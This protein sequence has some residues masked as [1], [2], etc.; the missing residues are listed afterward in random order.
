MV[1]VMCVCVMVRVRVC[2]FVCHGEGVCMGVD[3]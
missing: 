2:V 1:G 3:V